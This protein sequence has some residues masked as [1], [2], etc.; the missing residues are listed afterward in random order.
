[1]EHWNLEFTATSLYKL[2]QF[3]GYFGPWTMVR[4]IVECRFPLRF[5]ALLSIAAYSLPLWSIRDS[6]ADRVCRDRG[7]EG[8]RARERKGEREKRTMAQRVCLYNDII[9]RCLFQCRCES[10][11]LKPSTTPIRH[12]LNT[13]A[14]H[15]SIS[16][17]PTTTTTQTMQRNHNT[18]GY[19]YY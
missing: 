8:E 2:I 9:C 6:I 3:L 7:R 18:L 13:A 17:A 11:L 4:L 12:A 5:A 10:C 19:M 1:M 15:S 14:T 16:A